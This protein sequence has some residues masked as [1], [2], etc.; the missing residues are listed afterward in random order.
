MGTVRVKSVEC[1]REGEGIY[2]I[3]FIKVMEWEHQRWYTLASI[4][5]HDCSDDL[6]LQTTFIHI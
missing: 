1:E 2:G 6:M 5:I 4:S 3:E